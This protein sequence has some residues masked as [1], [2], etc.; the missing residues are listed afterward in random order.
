MF[1]FKTINRQMEP[2]SQP[3]KKK[4]RNRSRKKKPQQ[5]AQFMEDRP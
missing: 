2:G 3:K 5:N 4:N 1:K